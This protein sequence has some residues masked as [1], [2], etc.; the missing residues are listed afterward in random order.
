MRKRR[1]PFRRRAETV[2]RSETLAC[3]VHRSS[4]EEDRHVQRLRPPRNHMMLWRMRELVEQHTTN[5]R[6]GSGTTVRS[7]P[8]PWGPG[9]GTGPGIGIP[10][11][12]GIGCTTRAAAAVGMSIVVAPAIMSRC[13]AAGIGCV[14]DRVAAML[15]IGL[16]PVVGDGLAAVRGLML[17]MPA[18]IT[19]VVVVVIVVVVVAFVPVIVP[20]IVPVFVLVMA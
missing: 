20:V 4:G 12:I 3:R 14:R 18:L 5:G 7:G 11:G 19:C 17:V 1:R 13:V 6:S 8:C 16:M 15:W 9:M 2:V 10:P